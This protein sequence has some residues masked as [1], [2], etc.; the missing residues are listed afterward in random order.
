M[1]LNEFMVEELVRKINYYFRT[2]VREV[3]ALTQV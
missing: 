2:F 1:P 3:N